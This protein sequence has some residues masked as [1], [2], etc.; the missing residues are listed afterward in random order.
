LDRHG[1]KS[2]W[3]SERSA[4]AP[5]TISEFRNGKKNVYS[6]ALA[7]LIE[8]LPIE[9]R[10]DFAREVAGGISGMSLLVENLSDEEL[11]ELLILI[12][13]RLPRSRA[14]KSIHA[15]A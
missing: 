3:L 1:I 11:A 8:S 7:R 6:D 15:V 12:A 4:V 5:Q 9:A 10:I 14:S 13:R 2:K